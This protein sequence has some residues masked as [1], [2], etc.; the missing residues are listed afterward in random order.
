MKKTYLFIALAMVAAMTVSCKN[1]NKKAKEASDANAEVVAAAKTILADDVLAKIDEIGK[2]FFDESGKFN[3]TTIISSHLTEEEKLVK[4]D[5]LLDPSEV[6]NYVTKTQKVNALAILISDRTLMEAYEMPLEEVNDAI[7]RLVAEVGAPITVEGRDNMTVSEKLDAAYKKC[8]E[9]GDLAFFWQFNFAM[10]NEFSYLVCQAPDIYYRNI[11]E[12]QSQAFHKRIVAIR[13]VLKTLAEYDPEV[14]LAWE[15]YLKFNTN[16]P[17]DKVKEEAY[18]SV[19]AA[20][21][22]QI[23][24]KESVAARRAEMLK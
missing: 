4:P 12:E 19:E 17:D 18:K 1:N 20:K 11:S 3:F 6:N 10:M 24:R 13:G 14:K 5:Y 2:P 21:E 8:K 15:T 7:A 23:A 22:A 9:S 16:Y